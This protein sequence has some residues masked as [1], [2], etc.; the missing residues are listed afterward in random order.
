VTQRGNRRQPTF[1]RDSDYRLYVKLLGEWCAKADTQVWAWCLMPNHVHLILVPG[2]EDG[3]RAALGETHRRYT[4][5]INAREG[6]LGHLWQ[7]RF[8]SFPMDERHLIAC[9]RYVEL[10][11]VRAGLVER[12]E[13]WAWSSAPAH[14]GLTRDGLTDTAPLLDR[15]PQWGALLESGL[16]D[17][18]R[19]AIR[20][21]ERSGYALGG[22]GFLDRLSEQT[23]RP[24]IPKPRGRPPRIK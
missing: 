5:A 23:G 21:S 24:V 4:R 9:A 12:P 6:W 13:D 14:L 11:P 7:S 16:H 1:F 18:E 8:A 2:H 17:E 19:E 20:A 22:R 15:I 3:L 10:N